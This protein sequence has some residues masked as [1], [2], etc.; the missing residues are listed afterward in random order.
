MRKHKLRLDD[1]AVEAFATAEM[2]E[3]LR[4]TVNGHQSGVD[5]CATCIQLLCATSRMQTPCCTRI[6]YECS[7]PVVC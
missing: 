6:E 2:D 1:L 4:G 7:L 5:T 3:S